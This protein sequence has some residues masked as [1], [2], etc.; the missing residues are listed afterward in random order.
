MSQLLVNTILP[1][2][3]WLDRFESRDGSEVVYFPRG[4]HEWDSSQP[5]RLANASVISASY[6]I[7]LLGHSVAAKDIATERIRYVVVGTPAEVDAE[8]DDE[9]SKLYEFGIGKLWSRSQDNTY[10]W[11][12]ARVTDMPQI[13]IGVKDNNIVPVVI[14]FVRYSDWYDAEPQIV[15]QTI[16]STPEN[17]VI[18]NP[19]SAQ[20]SSIQIDLRANTA[21]G[22]HDP[23]IT[24]LTTGEWFQIQ[25]IAASANDY[26]RI[27]VQEYRIEYSPDDGSTFFS[28]YANFSLGPTQ[29][30][31]LRLVRGTNTIQYENNGVPNVDLTFTYY[32]TYH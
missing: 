29:V 18:D 13:S 6:A 11:A 17:I 25:G 7:D 2:Q 26:L 28:N 22:Y 8:L 5:L 24:N 27:I 21:G 31:I 12:W 16:V 23:K 1:K 14:G 9:K 10:R 15:Q 3:R 32:L 4:E 19:G 30:G 20:V